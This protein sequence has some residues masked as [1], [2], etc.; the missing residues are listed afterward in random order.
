MG[1]MMR[2]GKVGAWDEGG[3]GGDTHVRWDSPSSMASKE[4]PTEWEA[5]G[6][7]ASALHESL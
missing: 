2:E 6:A 4:D 3:K 7:S 5:V 1:E